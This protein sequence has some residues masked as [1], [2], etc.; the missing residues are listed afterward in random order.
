[1]ISPSCDKREFIKAVQNKDYLEIIRTAEQEANAVDRLPYGARP[2]QKDSPLAIQTWKN[3]KWAIQEYRKFL[4]S[5]LFF[6]RYRSIKP[7][8]ISDSHFQL[9]CPVCENLVKK[10]QL[11]PEVMNF[12]EEE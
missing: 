12:F 5:F 7:A 4:G 9:F 3:R 11:E 10:G 1:M 6:M 2:K 8:G